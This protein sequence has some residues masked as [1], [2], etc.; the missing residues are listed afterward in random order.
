MLLTFEYDGSVLRD[1]IRDDDEETTREWLLVALLRDPRTV[2]DLAE[3][4]AEQ[5]PRD[6][7]GADID[8]IK[9]RLRQ[10]LG[11]MKFD[12]LA[13]KQTTKRNS[14]WMLNSVT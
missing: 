6:T 9:A 8:R 7:T 14:P 13:V 2:D 3:E 11:R 10:A 1:V 5:S 12:G 4:L